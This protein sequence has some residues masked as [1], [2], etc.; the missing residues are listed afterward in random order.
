MKALLLKVRAISAKI[1]YYKSTHSRAGQA[2]Y[3]QGSW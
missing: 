2:P 3:K 1:I